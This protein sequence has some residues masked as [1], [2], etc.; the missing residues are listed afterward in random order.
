MCS[1]APDIPDTSPA[2]LAQVSS[3]ERIADQQLG[4]QSDLLNYY[5]ARQSTLDAQTADILQRQQA[6]AEQ[7]AAQGQDIFDYQKQ[8]FRPVEESMAEQAMRDSTPQAYEKYAQQA[9]AAQASANANAQGQ[10][11]RVLTGMG[12][13]PNSGSFASMERGIQ[14]SNA[15]GLGAVANNSRDQA[16]NLAWARKADVA[17]IGKG[18][19]GAGN[20]AYQIATGANSAMTGALNQASQTAGAT[21]GAPTSYGALGV[22]SSGQATNALTD[23]Y[24]SQVQ[25][26]IAGSNGGGSSPLA[27]ALGTGLGYWA[28]TGF[29]F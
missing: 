24:K 15:A 13:N 16:E 4:L 1:S 6:I 19:V 27:S 21:M 26:A 20:G 23:I 25:G 12:V 28:S 8:V 14:L 3:N 10:A 5:K 18:L 9:V 2:L 11:S 17:G 29:K 7:T 22:Q